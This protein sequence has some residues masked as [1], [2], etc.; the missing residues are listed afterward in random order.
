MGNFGFSDFVEISKHS[1][2]M[3]VHILDRV[4]IS[5]VDPLEGRFPNP[6]QSASEEATSVALPSVALRAKGAICVSHLEFF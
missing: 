4:L 5:L 1:A 2:Q 3:I 6:T